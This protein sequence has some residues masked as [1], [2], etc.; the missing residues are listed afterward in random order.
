[1]EREWKAHVRGS[2]QAYHR[3]QNGGVVATKNETTPPAD[4][5][6]GSG[7]VAAAAMAVPDAAVSKPRSQQTT[8][9]GGLN[10][11]DKNG[12]S[13]QTGA[14]GA[15]VVS[16]SE[17]EARPNKEKRRAPQGKGKEN[18]SKLYRSG[19][20]WNDLPPGVQLVVMKVLSR[21]VRSLRQV[22]SLL[23]MRWT[24]VQEF[25]SLYNEEHKK[26]AQFVER[27]NNKQ[28]RVEQLRLA[29]RTREADELGRKRVRGAQLAIH[30][31]T[32]QHLHWGQRYLEFMGLQD[33]AR[34]LQ[35]YVTTGEELM[36]QIGF[37]DMG[38]VGL[39]PLVFP[40]GFYRMSNP[41]RERLKDLLIRRPA[42]DKEELNAAA[43]IRDGS[44]SGRTASGLP[45]PIG[46]DP[47]PLE[48]N[49]SQLQRE[50]AP[51]VP[52]PAQQPSL[53]ALREMMPR[54]PRSQKATRPMTGDNPNMQSQSGKSSIGP[55]YFGSVD[56]MFKV[57]S[58][59]DQQDQVE[60]APEA[61]G[62]VD[63]APEPLPANSQSGQHDQN[64]PDPQNSVPVIIIED[65]AGDDEEYQELEDGDKS[66]GDD[67][68]DDDYIPDSTSVKK[69][70]LPKPPP[71]SLK[72]KR[73]DSS[74]NVGGSP[75]RPRPDAALQ[76]TPGVARPRPKIVIKASARDQIHDTLGDAD[77]IV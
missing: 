77:Y 26:I 38:E 44:R 2:K 25:E 12:N 52:A 17:N 19:I 67:D 57:P 13:A 43:R 29:G 15:L 1:M 4:P 72:R 70:S 27:W 16:K 53:K 55:L 60:V 48:G 58:G 51:V 32:E 9:G 31:N 56:D 69:S 39:E 6:A 54:I 62:P 41:E 21:S 33:L 35:D 63:Q 24:E 14:I 64:M 30:A 3:A 28:G 11:P 37:D 75:K 8:P 23:D 20:Q 47:W 18:P 65:D 61:S 10:L 76:A 34:R 40:N 42:P 36:F 45:R 66:D 46:V 73:A 59:S 74:E 71:V 50:P 22:A 68:E 5:Q 49:R 7:S